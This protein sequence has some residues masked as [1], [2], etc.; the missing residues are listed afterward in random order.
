MIFASHN[1]KYVCE[2]SWVQF[3]QRPASFL[4]CSSTF[5]YIFH[6]FVHLFAVFLLSFWQFFVYSIHL[7]ATSLLCFCC[8][9]G[10]F[11]TPFWLLFA[12]FLLCLCY[13]FRLFV[14]V[15]AHNVHTGVLTVGCVGHKNVKTVLAGSRYFVRRYSMR[16]STMFLLF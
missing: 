1:S 3:P 9:F 15:F 8:L 5:C 6:L 12:V 7:F 14:H 2:R 10:I 13:V 11:T 4:L 16:S